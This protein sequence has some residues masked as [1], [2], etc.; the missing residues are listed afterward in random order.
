MIYIYISCRGHYSTSKN[1]WHIRETPEEGKRDYKLLDKIPARLL[2][3]NLHISAQ[4]RTNT[5]GLRG[6]R[7]HNLAGKHFSLYKSG[8]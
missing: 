5:Q 4:R 8:I 2:V 6:P 7:T 3:R 1:L